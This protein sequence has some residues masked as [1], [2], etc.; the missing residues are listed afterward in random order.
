MRHSPPR[1]V[2]LRP[3]YAAAYPGIEG[4]QLQPLAPEA[5]RSARFAGGFGFRK[6]VFGSHAGLGGSRA[7]AGRA[8]SGFSRDL[9]GHQKG[10]GQGTRGRETRA[11]PAL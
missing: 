1:E 9:G 7:N 2:Q 6:D 4:E 8:F 5:A 10:L 11:H 3:E